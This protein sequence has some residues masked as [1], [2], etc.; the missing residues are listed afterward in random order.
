MCRE[1]YCVQF[2]FGTIW[3]AGASPCIVSWGDWMADEYV[4]VVDGDEMNRKLMELLLGMHGYKVRTATDGPSTFASLQRSQPLIILL[5]LKLR[6]MDGYSLARSLKSEVST[7]SIPIVAV[8]SEVMPGV[9]VRARLSG[10]DEY[11]PKPIDVIAFPSILKGV[12][13]RFR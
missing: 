10:C 13:D 12:L 11:V 1:A 2:R 6:G 9:E 5:E 8:T 4:L 3:P 7:R